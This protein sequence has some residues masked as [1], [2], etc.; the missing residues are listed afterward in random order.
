VPET[1]VYEHKRKKRKHLLSNGEVCGNLWDGIACRD[2][3]IGNDKLVES[4]SLGQ[5]YQ[6]QQYI[7]CNNDGIDNRVVLGLNCVANGYHKI[8]F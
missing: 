8:I 2:Q 3:S 6:V 4:I 7:R 1:A 5:L